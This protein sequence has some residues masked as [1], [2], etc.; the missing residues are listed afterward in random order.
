MV[1]FALGILFSFTQIYADY[2]KQRTE[3]S[4]TVMQVIRTMEQSATEAAFFLDANQA[5]QVSLGLFEYQP[6]TSVKLVS[7][8]GGDEATDALVSQSRPLQNRPFQGITKLLFGDQQKHEISLFHPDFNDGRVGKL[9]VVSDPYEVASAFMAR[10]ATV[11]ALGILR[12]G[13]LA[14]ILLIYFYYTITR[15]LQVMSRTWANISPENPSHNRLKVPTRHQTD[16][17]GVVIRRANLV[18][19]SI[20]DQLDQRRAAEKSLQ[21]SKEGLLQILDNS[22]YGVSIMSKETRKRIY[23]NRRFVSMFG[24]ESI[25]DFID[26]H[27]TSSFCDPAKLEQNWRDFDR[28]GFIS[29]SEQMRLRLNG[30]P[31]WCLVDMSSLP[32]NGED[33]VMTWHSDINERKQAEENLKGQTEL[34]NLQRKTADDANTARDFDDALHACLSTII[35]FMG[36]P[37]GHIYL[38]PENKQ[39][40]LVPSGIWQLN[41]PEQFAS[42]RKVTEQTVI[43]PGEAFVSRAFAT[44][45]P[46]WVEDVTQHP[47][48]SRAGIPGQNIG[49]RAG[50]AL[51]VIALGQVVSVLEFY[52]DQVIE[53]D[54]ELMLSLV[55]I[56]TQL[57]RVFERKQAE[58]ELREAMNEIDIANR[59]LEQKVEERTN[60]LHGAIIEANAASRVK[61]EFLANMSHELRTPLNAIIGFSEMIKEAMLGPL[62]N[63]YQDYAKDINDSGLHLLRIISDILDLSKVESGEFFIKEEIISLVDV[64]AACDTMMR[65][66]AKQASV[67]LTFR[68]SNKLPLLYADPVRLKQIL[69][70]LIGNAIKFTPEGGQVTVTGKTNEDGG[71][72]LEVRDTG[73]GIAKQDIPRVL[74]KFGQVR[75]GHTHAHEGAGLGLALTKSLMEQHGG[76]LEISSELNIGTTVT[77]TFPPDRTRQQPGYKIDGDVNKPR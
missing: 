75:E 9:T 13:I 22:P 72:V 47:A 77:V 74:E 21:R 36:W 76:R 54:D 24:G 8:F 35:E 29:G 32:F 19:D 30:E 69:L 6:I 18:L 53:Q 60:Q 23:V 28:D 52:S 4:S 63:K 37:V 11:L 46:V 61:T 17:F 39:D 56:G 38:L 50:I 67:P 3:L 64:T 15:P 59:S 41:N 49:V 16:E 48:Y 26:Q 25:D 5:R 40:H 57:S 66:R 27:E 44:G 70:N 2:R 33:A 1:T 10:S 34:V 20:E 7:S 31:W 14:C 68:I 42:F 43:R 71:V 62:Q 51:P 73:I 58:T 45:K 12:T 55:H 65:D